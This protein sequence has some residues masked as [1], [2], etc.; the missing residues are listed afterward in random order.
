MFPHQ[1]IADM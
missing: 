1:L